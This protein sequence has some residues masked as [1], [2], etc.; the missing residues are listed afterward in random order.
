MGIRSTAEVKHHASG[1]PPAMIRAIVGVAHVEGKQALSFARTGYTEASIEFADRAGVALF[2][3]D[4][5]LGTLQA[6]SEAAQRALAAASLSSF[7][8]A[9]C[10]LEERIAECPIQ[11]SVSGGIKIGQKRAFPAH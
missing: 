9:R 4:F 7:P 5:A 6:R 10:G 2:V 1:I 11:G 3:Y 8:G